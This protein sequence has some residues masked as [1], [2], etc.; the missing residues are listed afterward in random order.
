MCVIWNFQ[1]S[2][3]PD[4]KERLLFHHK[5]N[6]LVSLRHRKCQRWYFVWKALVL[7]PEIFL[8]P[9]YQKHVWVILTKSNIVFNTLVWFLCEV[10][11]CTFNIG[12]TKR[13]RFTSLF[14]IEKL[15]FSILNFY[16]LVTQNTFIT[17]DVESPSPE[18]DGEFKSTAPPVDL[19][20]TTNPSL[21]QTNGTLPHA[22]GVDIHHGEDDE[23]A[24]PRYFI[25]GTEFNGG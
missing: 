24:T 10:V 13:G 21:L 18:P 15:E 25:L 19:V 16:H 20:F 4:I 7:I 9:P 6:S 2:L 22:G 11:C 5:E 14:V 12:V 23:F 8:N 17:A 1:K 3:I